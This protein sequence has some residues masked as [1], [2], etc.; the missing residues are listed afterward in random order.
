[1]LGLLL[2]WGPIAHVLSLIAVAAGVIAGVGFLRLVLVL[3]LAAAHRGRRRRSRRWRRRW[4]PGTSRR[5]RQC[6][7]GPIRHGFRRSGCGDLGR[8]RRRDRCRARL[9]RP[10]SGWHRPARW[11]LRRLRARRRWYRYGPAHGGGLRLIRR[12]SGRRR[13]CEGEVGG[14][15]QRRWIGGGCRGRRR[16]PRWRRAEERQRSGAMREHQWGNGSCRTRQ[17]SARPSEEKNNDQG[18]NHS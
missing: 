13:G 16:Q 17:E 15:G 9:R 3:L 7:P 5:R 8:I 14:G 4:R 1:M 11:Y 6:R 18:R 2:G 12:C 10:R